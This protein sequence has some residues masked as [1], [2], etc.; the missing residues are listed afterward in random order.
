MLRNRFLRDS[1]VVSS[2]N[3]HTL[4]LFKNTFVEKKWQIQS[5]FKQ[6]E[7]WEYIVPHVSNII[8]FLLCD[9]IS[10]FFVK[11]ED[12]FIW[13]QFWVKI[14]E[15]FIENLLQKFAEKRIISDCNFNHCG[16]IKLKSNYRCSISIPYGKSF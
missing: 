5:Y 8:Q 12:N 7:F 16:A 4:V 6:N 1:T 15:L 3:T 9:F 13:Y 11:I 10:L 2:A 14:L